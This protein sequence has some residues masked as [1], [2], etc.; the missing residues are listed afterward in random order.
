[1]KN[2]FIVA[3]EDSNLYSIFINAF[4]LDEGEL[5]YDEKYL[6][7]ELNEAVNLFK[8]KNRNEDYHTYYYL[9]S[10]LER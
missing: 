5:V 8:V 3:E 6:D 9:R 4:F 2:I 10:Q 1:M 7:L